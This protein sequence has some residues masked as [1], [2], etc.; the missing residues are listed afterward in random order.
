[1]LGASRLPDTEI[2][3]KEKETHRWAAA[4]G[5]A[6]TCAISFA[7]QEAGLGKGHQPQKSGQSTH[8]EGSWDDGT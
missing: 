2:S 8:P 6:Y 7:D 4:H 1:M 5:L 3:P